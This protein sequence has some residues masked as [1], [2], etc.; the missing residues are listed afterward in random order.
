LNVPG[1]SQYGTTVV[2]KV[3][4]SLFLVDWYTQ[5]VTRGGMLMSGSP[6]E[7]NYA[8]NLT[9]PEAVAALRGIVDLK[10]FAPPDVLEFGISESVQAMASGRVA[11]QLM[12]TTMS[13]SLFDSRSST[14]A[15]RIA[16]AP[17]PGE[18]PFAGQA[19]RGGWG[20]GIPRNSLVNEAAWQALVYLTSRAFERYQT[21][22]YLTT[23]NRRSVF[24]DPELRAAQPYLGAA[25]D[26]LERARIL[27]IAAI[28]ETFELID[29]ASRRFHAALSGQEGVEEALAKANEDWVEVLKRGGHLR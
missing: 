18:G 5:F 12:W 29:V 27:E 6:A 20:F 26:A 8:P 1:R 2:G 22:T 11:M 7:G 15:D 19:I 28:P 13:G 16:V 25:R 3:N 21:A 23:P 4:P 14:V 17:M 24:E 9:S 10:A